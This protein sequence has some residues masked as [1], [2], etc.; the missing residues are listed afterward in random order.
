MR[1]F[2][3]GFQWYSSENV[4]LLGVSDNNCKWFK[5]HNH[6]FRYEM[7]SLIQFKWGM[8]SPGELAIQHHT[9]CSQMWW[10]TIHFSVSSRDCR[11]IFVPKWVSIQGFVKFVIAWTL[12]R[13]STVIHVSHM[14]CW[15]AFSWI[16][17]RA[18]YLHSVFVPDMLK[19][20]NLSQESSLYHMFQIVTIATSILILCYTEIRRKV[21]V[22]YSKY[23]HKLSRVYT[24]VNN[25]P[26]SLHPA[27]IH[28][29]HQ[30][31]H[32]D[33]HFS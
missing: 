7:W 21:K 17:A 33:L 15:P 8:V 27:T 25:T 9:C 1:F 29:A 18:R 23:F 11:C 24:V 13:Y 3:L 31:T 19:H 16:L 30:H 20:V 6:Y 14:C 26:P 10:E 5:Q 32:S 12:L 4:I 2:V 22:C 28:T